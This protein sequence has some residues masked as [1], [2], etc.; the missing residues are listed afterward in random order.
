MYDNAQANFNVVCIV[1]GLEDPSLL[2]I[3]H[4]RTCLFHSATNMDKDIE[5]VLAKEF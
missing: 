2:M 3:D 4:V 1:Y 5:K